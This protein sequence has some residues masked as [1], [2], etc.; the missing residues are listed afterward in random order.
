[1]SWEELEKEISDL[2]SKIR[3]PFDIIVG[4]VRGGIVPARMLSKRLKV[5][6]MYCLTVKKLGNERKVMNEISEDIRGKNII[7]IEDMIETG[8]SLIATKEYLEEKGAFVKTAC[9]YI[10]PISEIKPDYFLKEVKEVISF[11]WE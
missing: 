1:M 11:P 7:L 2:S 5:N 3:E 10:M 9:L 4:I 8:R 6:S